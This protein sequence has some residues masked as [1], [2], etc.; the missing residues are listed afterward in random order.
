MGI[1]LPM[2][3]SNSITEEQW[4]EAYQEALQMAEILPCLDIS[5]VTPKGY[6]IICGIRTHEREGRNGE[7]GW[8]TVGDCETFGNAEDYSMHR[9]R[10]TKFFLNEPY[11]ALFYVASLRLSIDPDD[12]RVKNKATQIWGAKTQGERYHMYLLAIACRLEERFPKL[13]AVSGDI[14]QGQCLK[15]AEI[16]SKVLGRTVSAPDC[17]YPDRLWNRV[18]EFPL[19]DTEKVEAYMELYCGAKDGELG[20]FLRET[21]DGSILQSY[22]K[23]MLGMYVPGC[24]GYSEQ[25]RDFLSMGFELSD[26]CAFSR[27]KDEKGKSCLK[28]FVDSVMQ[29]ELHIEKKD[30]VDPLSIDPN[31]S[32]PYSIWTLMAQFVFRGVHNWRVDRYMPLEDI[33]KVL[34]NA[35]S[36]EGDTDALVDKWIRAEKRKQKKSEKDP[37]A[38]PDVA[39]K[40]S[41]DSLSDELSQ[42]EKT[43]DVHKCFQLRHYEP[44]NTITPL[45]LH[46]TLRL[47][48]FSLTLNED[49]TLARLKGADMDDHIRYIGH[50]S[51]HILLMGNDWDRILDRLKKDD[52]C[53]MRY[54]GLLR[55]KA[56]TDDVAHILAA[57]LTNDDLWEY[58]QNYAEAHPD[59]GNFEQDNDTE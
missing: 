34:C 49:K 35:L 56:T 40:E 19:V 31:Q 46:N 23:Q 59:E 39:F 58:I 43:Y 14:T 24:I 21:I 26:A 1:Y 12:E 33:K 15:A 32:S 42:E 38:K 41:M 53:F 57:L 47:Y 48:R 30:T 54:L 52:S 27:M 20:K 22:W 13:F 16:A 55:I 51:Q 36:S 3:V 17:C 37:L 10:Q 5:N 4:N 18:Q 45:I 2:F 25:L 50:C 8:H 11:D 44:G 9:K 29:S 7:R 6:P 28:A